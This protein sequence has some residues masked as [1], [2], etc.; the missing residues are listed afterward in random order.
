MFVLLTRYYSGDQINNSEMGG[1][2]SM[3]GER[4]CAYRVLGG[5]PERQR[6]LGKPRHRW[7]NSIKIDLQVLRCRH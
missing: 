1:A 5:K 3:Y 4:R 2:R 6:P 7:E